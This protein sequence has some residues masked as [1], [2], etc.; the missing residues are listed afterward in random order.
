MTRI[1]VVF[2][3]LIVNSNNAFSQV[4]ELPERYRKDRQLS[5][6]RIVRK[7]KAIFSDETLCYLGK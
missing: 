6:Q 7:G 2:M 4:D 1:V 3:L 5:D